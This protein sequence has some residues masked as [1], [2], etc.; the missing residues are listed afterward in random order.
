M[1]HPSPSLNAESFSA[2]LDS[3]L[4]SDAE[5]TS[6]LGADPPDT[7]MTSA[8][9][10]VSTDVVLPGTQLS[11]AF[12]TS[13]PRFKTCCPS[14]S[15]RDCSENNAEDTSLI[16]AKVPDNR[17]TSAFETHSF[18]IVLPSTQFIGPSAT[19]AARLLSELSPPHIDAKSTTSILSEALFQTIVPSADSQFLTA[20]ARI[21]NSEPAKEDTS[22]SNTRLPGI[23]YDL[24]KFEKSSTPGDVLIV[25]LGS[26][27]D[28]TVVDESSSKHQS[29]DRAGSSASSE[30]PSSLFFKVTKRG[31]SADEDLPDTQSEAWVC[32]EALAEKQAAR[33][34]KMTSGNASS[35]SPSITSSAFRRHAINGDVAREDPS[36]VSCIPQAGRMAE[37]QAE[38]D[39]IVD[40]DEPPTFRQPT[41]EPKNVGSTVS[42]LSFSSQASSTTISH[43]KQPLNKISCRERKRIIVSPG[44]PPNVTKAMTAWVKK[45]NWL[46]DPFREDDDCWFHPSPRPPRIGPGSIHRPVGKLQKVFMWQDRGGKHTIV[47]NFGIAV[48]LINYQM[49]KQQ[50]DGFINKQWHLSHLCGNWTCLNPA[51]TTVEPGYV[52]ISRNNCFSHRSGCLHTPKCLK[53]K[54]VALGADNLLVNHN[55]PSISVMDLSAADE[56]S[57]WSP[58]EFQEEEDKMMMDSIVRSEVISDDGHNHSDDI[59]SDIGVSSHDNNLV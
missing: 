44:R 7:Q 24:S 53:D 4:N 39:S 9:E 10:M 14:A 41:L 40:G 25:R 37:S 33:N 56:S 19:S 47:L 57:D 5:D 27:Q 43:L 20:Q 35:R 8:S 54:K 18:D 2:S 42:S 34:E 55:N 29:D 28:P 6:L 51:H 22:L 23:Q 3:C 17:M 38:D 1:P 50:Q 59:Q 32:H 46:L 13:T 11:G 26:V 31:L 12:A 58:Q 48:K 45:T 21:V 49:T 36:D 52:N 15:P 16:V 30:A